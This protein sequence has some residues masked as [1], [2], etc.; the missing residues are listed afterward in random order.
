MSDRRMSSSKFGFRVIVV[1]CKS[2][3]ALL[4]L[5]ELLHTTEFE[6]E[7]F[8]KTVLW[9]PATTNVSVFQEEHNDT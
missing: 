7:S 5:P 4:E 2:L 1:C 6:V 8:S 9:T 3:D